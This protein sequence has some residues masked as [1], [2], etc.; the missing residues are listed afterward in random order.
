MFRGSPRSA[1]RLL[2]ALLLALQVAVVGAAPVGAAESAFRLDLAGK[3]DYVAQTNFVQCVGASMQMML[4]V[5]N[6]ENDRTAK[7]QLR[8]QNLAR[9]LSGRRGDGSER[10]GASVRGWSA[11]LNQ[12]GAGPYRLVGT[13]TIDEALRLAA[14][15]IRQTNRPVGL[16]VWRGR[17][18]WVMSG[19]R[20][21]ADPRTTNDFRV[22]SV[23]VEEAD[24]LSAR[25]TGTKHVATWGMAALKR[26]DFIVDGKQRV[27][28]LR[29]QKTP[30]L[31]QQHNRLGA[32]FVPRD[33]KS[34]DLILHV[35]NGSPAYEAGIRNGDVL[36]KVGGRDVTKAEPI[37]ENE[38]S[39]YDPAGT[40]LKLTVKRGDED[41]SLVHGRSPR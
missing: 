22:T 27:A 32:T 34:E 21:T 8:L 38:P 7:T 20:A 4:N 35:A 39:I 10:R 13:T 14:Y 28:Y 2:L 11:G 25:W 31:P 16:L 23:I 30:P 15:A 40:K 19:F 9:E 5:I 41:V 37:P 29:P 17:H 36:L 26:L 3:G 18:A 12:L 24:S 33:A 1:A 6:P